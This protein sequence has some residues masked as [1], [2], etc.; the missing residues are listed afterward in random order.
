MAAA[1]ATLAAYGSMMLIS[2]FLGRRYYRV[3]YNVKKISFYLFL[4]TGISLISFV[5]FRENYLAGT[6]FV[7]LFLLIA[8]MNER[9]DLKKILKQ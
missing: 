2:Y 3:P 6:A 4:G 7:V 9:R 8:F 5:F 1:W